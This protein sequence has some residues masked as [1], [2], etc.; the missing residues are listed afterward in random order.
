MADD[1]APPPNAGALPEIFK[2]T[3]YNPAFRENPYAV[4]DE[5]RDDAARRCATTAGAASSSRATTTS[6]RWSPTGRCGA[7]R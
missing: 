3:P 1:T 6:G 4:L 5:L 7:I 2:L